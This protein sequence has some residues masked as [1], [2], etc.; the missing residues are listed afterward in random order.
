MP[1]RFARAP[2]TTSPAETDNTKSDP[3]LPPMKL[4]RQDIQ[5][6]ADWSADCN[7]LHVDPAFARDTHFGQPIAHGVL[8]VI[9]ALAST[10]GSRGPL[11]R[12]DVEFRGAVV[13][14]VSYGLQATDTLDGLAVTVNGSEGS[15]LHIRAA[16]GAAGSDNEFAMDGAWCEALASEPA[17]PLRAVPAIRTTD[18]FE[19]GLELSGRYTTPPPP[20]DY[21]GGLIP[22]EARALALCSYVVGMEAPGLRSLFTRLTLEFAGQ[23][24]AGTTLWFRARTLRFDPHFRLLDTRIDIATPDGAPVAAGV[25]RCYVPLDLRGGDLHELSAHLSPATGC[26]EGKVAFLTGGSRGLGAD[27]GAAFAL[28][29]CHVYVAARR[30]STAASRLRSLLAERGCHVE[31]L[32]GDVGDAAW[33]RSALD[34]ILA[35]HARL[36]VVVLNACAAPSALR[37]T[38]DAAE[39]QE[40]YLRENLRLISTPLSLCLPTLDASKGAVALISSSFV[41]EAPAGFSHYVALKRAGE[42]LVHTARREWPHLCTLVARPPRLR[43]TWNDTPTGVA[44]AIPT[45]RAASHIVNRL[46]AGL[47]DGQAD[48]VLSEFPAFQKAPAAI[49][50]EGLTDFPV[51]LVASFTTDP[52]LPGLTFWLR[53]LGLR[54]DVDVAPYGQI[55]QSLLDPASAFSRR[56]GLNVVMLR[57][58]DWLRELAPEHAEEIDFVRSHLDRMRQDLAGAVRAHRGR[59]AGET[60]LVICPSHGA[61]SPAVSI[62]L[63]RTESELVAGLA[64]ISGLLVVMAA[65][66]HE[67]HGVDDDAIRDPLREKLAHIPYRESYYHVLATIV[68][69]HVHRRVAPV[70]KVVVVDCDNTLW[71][72][73]VGEVGAE[74]VE[75]T[76]AHVALH[77]TLTRLTHS[78]LLLCLCSKN[79]EADVWRVFETRPDL[80]LRREDV[81]AAAINWQPKSENL[82]ALAA[83][84][85]LGIDSFIFID[86]NPVECAEVR[87]RCPEVLTLQWPTDPGRAAQLLNHAWELDVVQPSKEDAKR[88]LMYREEFRRQELREGAHTFADFIST[89]ALEVDVAPLAPDDLRRASQLTLRTNQFNFTTKRR[90]EADVQAL[91]SDGRYEVRTIRVRDRFGD[92]GLVGLVIAERQDA[93][94]MTDTFLLS[95][96]VL[97]RGVEHR[98]ASELGRIALD[99]GLSTVRMRVEITKRNT[100]ARSFLESIA[101][102]GAR[103]SDADALECDL[104]ARDLARL[105]FTPADDG[106]AV[107]DEAEAAPPASSSA[108]GIDRTRR[109]EEQIA[110]TAYEWSA[111]DRLQATLEDVRPTGALAPAPGERQAD[112]SDVAAAVYGA[113]SRALCVSEHRV[114]EVDALEAL[115]CD[116]LKIVEITVALLEKFPWLPSTLLFE[117]RTITQI[118]EEVGR[119]AQPGRPEA[120]SLAVASVGRSNDTGQSVGDIAVVGMHVRCSGADSPDELW[121]LLSSATS[122]VRQV[123]PGSQ[124]FLHPLADDRPHWAALLDD[125]ARFDAEFFG[126]SPRE[127]EIVD[128]QL[129]IFLEVAWNALEDAGG[130]GGRHEPDTGVFVGVMYG[131]YGGPANLEAKASG[132]PYRSW[133]GFSLANRLSQLLGFHGP[134][135]AVDTACSSSGTA[136]HLACRALEAGDCRAAVVGGVNLILDPDRFG[137]LG[138]LGI[139]STRGRCEPFGADA[140]GTVLGEGAGAVVLRPLS[141]A[142]RRG[143]HIYGVIKGTGLSTGSGTVGFTAPNPQAQAEAIRRSLAAAGMDPRTITYVETHGTGT[144]LGDPIE[145][146]GLTLGYSSAELQDP[147]VEVAHRC[148]IG[149]IKPNIGHL[150]AGAGVVGLVKVLLQLQHGMLVPSIT[151]SAA[152]PQ[153]PFDQIAFDVQRQLEPW[154]RLV[155]QANGMVETVPRRAGLSSFGVGGANVHVIVEEAPPVVPAPASAPERPLHILA[156]SAPS[157]ESLRHQAADVKR[158]LE[159]QTDA[160]L[161][162]LCFSVNT[163]RRH[164]DRRLALTAGSR[165]ECLDRLAK[166][167]EGDEPTG[168]IRGN[169]SPGSGPK[170]AFLFTGQGS[171]HAGMGKQLYEEQPVFRAAVDRCASILDPVL[172]RSLVDLL[173]ARE[174]GPD[175]DLLNQTGYTQPA[176]FAF[177]YA[178][179]E[180][181]RSW[182]IRPNVVLGHSV[183]ELTAMCV[184]G[185]MSLEEGL[186]LVA[187]RGRLMQALPPGGTMTSVMAAEDRVLRAI[188]GKQDLVAIAAVNA[189]RQV[190]ISGVGAAVAD[191]SA[192]LAADGIKTKSLVVSHAFHSPLMKPMLEE[193]ERVVREIR[194]TTPKIPLVSCVDGV[195]TREITQPRYWLRQV[196]EP[197]RFTTGV[198]TLQEQQV[199]AYV[200][201]GPRPVL[202]GM[203]R[204]CVSED[205]AEKIAW[206]PSVRPDVGNWQT[207]LGSAASLYVRGAA[208]DWKGFDEPYGR[209]RMAVPTYPFDPKQYWLKRRDVRPR[210]EAVREE[211]GEAV[212]SSATNQGRAAATEVYEVAW[213]KAPPLSPAAPTGNQTSTRRMVLLVDEGGVG[214]VLARVLMRDGA[215]VVMVRPGEGFAQEA[216]NQ[217]RVNPESPDDFLRLWEALAADGEPAPSVVHLW[218]LRAADTDRL[219]VEGLDDVVRISVD[220]AVH[221]VQMLVN[222][223]QPGPAMWVVTRGAVATSRGG[224]PL[225][226]AQAPLWGFARTAG[227]EH[228]EA[229]GGIVDLSPGPLQEAEILALARQLAGVDNE[230]Q[231]ALRGEERHVPRLVRRAASAPDGLSLDPQG[232][233]LVTGGLGALGLHVA[234]WLVRSGARHIVLAGRRGAPDEAA[235]SAIASLERLGA[236]VTV[237]AADVSREADIDALLAMIAKG[238]APLRGVVHAAGVDH[239]VPLVDLTPGDVQAVMAPKVRGGWILHERTR[240]LP[241]DL[242]LCFSSIASVLGSAGRAHYSAA[243]AF[244]DALALERRRQ[245]LAGL[246]VGWGPWSGGGMAA[247]AQLEQFDRVGNYALDPAEAVAV[248]DGLVRTQAAQV[249]VAKIDW[250]RFRPIYEAKRPRP[251]VSALG[252]RDGTQPLS[253]A[254][255]SEWVARLSLTPPAARGPMLVQL[256]RAE[257]ADTLGFD[258]PDSVPVDRSLYQLGMDSL[259]MADF[260]GRLRKRLGF[261]TAA[262]V[263]DHPFV[264]ALA[265]RLLEQIPVPDAMPGVAPA[266]SAPPDAAP[267]AASSRDDG[268]DGYS[269]GVEPDIVEFQKQAWPRRRT[270]WIGPRWRWLYLSS[271]RRLGLEPRMWLYRDA[272][273]IVGYTGAIPVRVKIGSEERG[274]AWL[275]DT[276]VLEAYRQ[277]AVGSRLMVRAHEDLPF[278]LSLGQTAEMRE[279]QLRLGW[280]RVASLETAQLLIRPENVL[281]GKLPWP[282]AVAAGWGLR[283]SSAVRD[284]LRDRTRSEIRPVARFDE[285]HDRLWACVA[286]TITCGVVRDASYLNWKYVD[287]P[288]QEF[289]RLEMV[290]GNSVTGVA[291]LMFREP[292]EGY[293]YR[294]AFLVDLVAPLN[295]E[296]RLAQLIEAGSAAAAARGA[297]ALL[298]LHIGAP[299]TR[300][301]RGQGFTLRAPERY[302]LVDPGPLDGLALDQVLSADSWFVTQGDSDIDRPW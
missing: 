168:C 108:S 281:K 247:P 132:N 198:K 180:L 277:Q 15:V 246:S 50:S 239:P 156:L 256:L 190:V 169:V 43:T 167:V 32:T 89:L 8:S 26:L 135:L 238:P 144:A 40:A 157:E 276:M 255:A 59:A 301:L 150:E 204:Q 241:L 10:A 114:K 229:W 195:V 33:C 259:M 66:Y 170:V 97:G 240:S 140:D 45:E 215:G 193:Y 105:E 123:D 187:A 92:Y 244:L 234:G 182:G 194:F 138:R 196:M 142:L 269:S 172:D 192:G 268:V 147:R 280:K 74:G 296:H 165:R 117:H 282:A 24:H 77:A 183:G 248:L 145:V 80:G 4:V 64:G 270:D 126:V 107:V 213:Q 99:S 44:G 188:A 210:S 133:E 87:A 178:L 216:R 251:L 7:P 166:V 264:E 221:A 139:L 54:E 214:A 254:D 130:T 23:V 236:S 104:P 41:E 93:L 118:L 1:S 71:G 302:L 46:A 116:S 111:A 203:A 287:Q 57:V 146:R 122:A 279:V 48:V 101:S 179:T 293:H 208:I 79:E 21:L 237:A 271:A 209:T 31:L 273:T 22:I 267:A 19:N 199:T 2:L 295:D 226:L 128:P 106:G 298:C 181:W 68:A 175:A 100:P 153:I 90:A 69:R 228:P 151:S 119:L 34:Q 109:R 14:D 141:E 30:D 56:G 266:D 85:N 217:Y 78:G 184:A 189:P 160:V 125:V 201:I 95:C 191:I 112:V 253:V 94:L 227:L 38:P 225:S 61:P 63:Q 284:L 174:D 185:G 53:E 235:A 224:D 245:G 297:D 35:R 207:M 149:S 143:D 81:V 232:T 98:I 260:V 218:G 60:L 275:A 129:R 155:I 289:V 28:A 261:S 262:L 86:D 96:R 300:A 231:V 3:A 219:N 6:F 115:G 102:V 84:L 82:R 285:R 148:R 242:F 51:R 163:G 37:I 278:A 16:A 88:V 202:L 233:Y 222:A 25:L 36:D 186:K 29:G 159:A 72:G 75:I 161:P 83:R 124:R 67:R 230:D 131:D 9:S 113:F 120:E 152:N 58:H 73:V 220:A 288:G 62:L 134:S 127:A 205:D 158:F 197:V 136:L 164:F 171:Q 17:R 223:G 249:S 211:R 70:R 42:A 252:A 52:L 162:Q 290:E 265:A 258:T 274:S 12:L 13:P 5:R 110:R 250:D 154:E 292:G 243:N 121:Q 76:P 206:L 137:S 65:D 49:P 11:R 27:I 299:I 294:R 47:S 212:A 39:K 176:L 20:A 200:E 55:L 91:A 286:G 18:E 272:G 283:A 263:F 257:V 173:F 291:V 177:E 103:R